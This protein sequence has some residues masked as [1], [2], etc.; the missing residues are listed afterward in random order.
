MKQSVCLRRAKHGCACVHYSVLDD[1]HPKPIDGVHC[2][3]GPWIFRA[4]LLCSPPNESKVLTMLLFGSRA[5]TGAR[6]RWRAAVAWRAA[7]QKISYFA[8]DSQFADNPESDPGPPRR[9]P[10]TQSGRGCHGD[11]RRRAA[12]RRIRIPGGLSRIRGLGAAP[13]PAPGSGPAA[14]V[15]LRLGRFIC[16][17]PAVTVTRCR[18]ARLYSRTW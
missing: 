7:V 2:E 5:A 15:T 14:T 8:I 10:S 12:R 4:H 1:L 16:L 9:P 17:G 13:G 11:C 18:S 6:R 3:K